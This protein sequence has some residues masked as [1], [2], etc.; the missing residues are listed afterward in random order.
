MISNARDLRILIGCVAAVCTMVGPVGAQRL[1][2]V[3]SEGVVVASGLGVEPEH[4]AQ[5]LVVKVLID[6]IQSEELPAVSGKYQ[7]NESANQLEFAPRFEFE[8]GVRYQALFHLGGKRIEKLDFEIASSE[9]APLAKVSAVYPS[10][11]TLPENH[12]RFYVHFS[13]PMSRGFAGKHIKLLTEEGDAVDLPFLELDQELWDPEGRRLT[14][15]LDPGRVKRGLKPRE[16]HGPVLEF[17]K[18]YS[19]V[20]DKGFQDARGVGMREGFSTSFKVELSDFDQPDTGRW[21]IRAP[22]LGSREPLRIKFGAPLDH[23]MLQ[24]MIAVFNDD[25]FEL[26]GEIEVSDGESVWSFVPAMPWRKGKPHA[27]G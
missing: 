13:Q 2:F 15:F 19:L 22:A 18:R 3:E 6:G 24:R 1:A 23:G 5:Q 11:D 4:P 20:V 27:S 17:G 8:E 16:D 12:L 21:Q 26:G 25:G 14:L 7:W 10:G 9:K